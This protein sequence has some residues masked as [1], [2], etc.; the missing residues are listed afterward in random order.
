MT[1]EERVPAVAGT[2]DATLCRHKKTSFLNDGTASRP[3]VYR[4]VETPVLAPTYSLFMVNSW[5]IR[6]NYML[7]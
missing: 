5:A 4:R 6:D 1:V 7:K 2:M 3:A